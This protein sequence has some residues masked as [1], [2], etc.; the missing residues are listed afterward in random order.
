MT[1]IRAF[2]CGWGVQSLAGMVLAARGEIDYQT[3]LFAN[4][5]NDSEH[6]G[7]LDYITKHGLPYAAA[8]GIEIIELRRVKRGATSP[9]LLEHLLTQT[10]SI[11]IPVRMNGNGAPG[12]RACTADYKIKVIEK[13]LRSQGAS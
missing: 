10:R 4:T 7:T 13:W 5:G 2:S 6:P 11:P 9:T 12:N 8:H 1:Q 3:F